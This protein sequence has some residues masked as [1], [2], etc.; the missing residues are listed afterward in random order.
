[1][2]SRSRSISIALAVLWLVLTGCNSFEA[3]NQSLNDIDQATLVSRGNIALDEGRYADALELF[4]RATEKGNPTDATNRGLA[5]A[6]AGLS[7]FNHFLTLRTMQNALIPPDSPATVFAA[8]ALLKDN[9]LL[10]QSID[11]LFSISAPTV[12]DRLLRGLLAAI[13]QARLLLEKYDTNFNGRLDKNDEIDF[14]TRD[15]K[16]AKWPELFAAATNNT[17]FYSLELAFYDLAQAFDGRGEPW[18]FI[19]PVAGTKYEGN[20]TPAN[21]ATVLA[22]ANFADALEAAQ[23]YFDK[24]ESLFKQTLISLDGVE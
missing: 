6:K 11:H 15:A 24:S 22:I 3:F 13:Y 9:S 1:M 12:Q 18:V 10:R 16:T 4:V 23:A 20:F 17:S 14:D 5:S 7:G 21:R 2:A 8:A 19:S